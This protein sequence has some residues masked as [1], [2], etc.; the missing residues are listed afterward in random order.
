MSR[1][2]KLALDGGVNRLKQ[3]GIT[4]PRLDVEVLLAHA[5]GMVREEIFIHFDRSLS[6]DELDKFES[7]IA[8][9]EAREPVSRI[10]GSKEFWSL[11]FKLNSA[12]LT[13]RPDSETLV[14]A[15]LQYLE[16]QNKKSE[17]HVLDFGTGTGC[18]LLAILSQLS[19]AQGLGVDTAPQAIIAA[20]ENAESLGLGDRAVFFGYSWVNDDAGIIEPEK[21][22]IIISNPPYIESNDIA[23]LEKEVS[24]FD[25]M[26]ALDGGVDGMDHYKVLAKVGVKYLAPN[27]CF[28]LEIGIGQDQSVENIFTEQGWLLNSQHSDVAG[29]KRVLSFKRK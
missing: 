12:T 21:F 1:N 8:R 13:P 28:F 22:D 7:Y 27:G 9:R 11:D 16:R 18:L 14:A 20:R 17:V 29:V 25:P 2:V 6:D 5:I 3:S 4:E 10:L 26:L 24:G 19:K 15:V 23:S